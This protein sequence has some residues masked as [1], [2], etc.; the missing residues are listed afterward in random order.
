MHIGEL[1]V[2]ATF[3]TKAAY[4]NADYCPGRADKHELP[5]FATTHGGSVLAKVFAAQ[6]IVESMG[7]AYLQTVNGS[8]VSPL[9]HLRVATMAYP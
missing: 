3:C 7:A 8:F 4:D 9:L 6:A 1:V 5:L 2:D